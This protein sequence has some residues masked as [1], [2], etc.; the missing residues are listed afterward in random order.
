MIPKA[1][2]THTNNLMRVLK[3]PVPSS[4]LLP[5]SIHK[6]AG[7]VGPAALDDAA[8]LARKNHEAH[9]PGSYF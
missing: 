1:T 2:P 6:G 9:L 3:R 7:L 8:K 4:T 5:S